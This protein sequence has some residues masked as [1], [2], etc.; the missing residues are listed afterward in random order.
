MT[1]N[2]LEARGLGF[3]FE[4]G[5][6]VLDE[7]SFS[8]APGEILAVIG[9]NGSGKST[10]IRLLSN[11][12]RPGAG[13]VLV[14]GRPLADF[15]GKQLAQKIA[16]VPQQTAVEFSYRVLEVVLMGRA[17][18]LGRFQLESENDLAI[19]RNALAA[20]DCLALEDRLLDEISG[21]ERQRVILARAL[22]QEPEILLADEPTTHLDLAR[23]VQFMTLLREL[24]DKQPVS[25]LFTTHELNLAGMFA[26]RILLLDRG[27]VAALGAPEQVLDPG[28][29]GKVYG[30]KLRPAS[31]ISGRSIFLAPALDKD[32]KL[33]QE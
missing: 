10:L 4:A 29:V 31:E 6:P 24:R 14:Q 3:S 11:V 32:T 9:P 12:L 18:Y 1:T 2:N 27:R 28:L 20:T 33:L 23:Q 30:I 22:A 16:V 19:A 21:G 5:K 17:P 25:I 8:I 15:T 13:E 7:I 26:D